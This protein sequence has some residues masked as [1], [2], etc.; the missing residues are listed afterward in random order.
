MKWGIGQ[1][2][3]LEGKLSLEEKIIFSFLIFTYYFRNNEQP[4]FIPLKLIK[5]FTKTTEISDWC[6]S[7]G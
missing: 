5:K 3:L 6:Y 4:L 7:D 2:F 1:K